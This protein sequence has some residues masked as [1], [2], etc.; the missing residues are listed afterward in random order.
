[1][2]GGSKKSSISATSNNDSMLVFNKDIYK[3]HDAI[4]ITDEA[5]KV[6]SKGLGEERTE[7]EL[8]ALRDVVA[9]MKLIHKGMQIIQESLCR[10]ITYEKHGAEEVLYRKP[11]EKFMSCYYVL[12]GTVRILYEQPTMNVKCGLIHQHYTGEYIGSIALIE[13]DPIATGA[14]LPIRMVVIDA[15]ELLRIDY[16]QFKLT[17]EAIQERHKKKKIEF[18]NETSVLKSLPQTDILRIIPKLS[19]QVKVN[20]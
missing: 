2:T 11:W 3:C 12:S 5:R 18:M 9:G 19:K 1:M 14:P 7:K 16:R 17:L 15:C 4:I 8:R 6:M 20:R 10:V 13:N